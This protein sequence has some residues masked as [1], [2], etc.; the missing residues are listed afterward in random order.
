MIMTKHIRTRVSSQSY[1]MGAAVLSVVA[2]AGSLG[3]PIKWN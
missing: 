2:L 3:A 1:R